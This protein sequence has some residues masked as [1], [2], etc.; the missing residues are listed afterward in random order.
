MRIIYSR[1]PDGGVG[2][3]WWNVT[4]QHIHVSNTIDPPPPP[5]HIGDQTLNVIA[6]SFKHIAFTEQP[7]NHRF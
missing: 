2:G 6:A 1:R 5:P 3:R 4:L 7:K